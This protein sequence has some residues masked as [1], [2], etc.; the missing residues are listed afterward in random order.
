V[1]ATASIRFKFTIPYRGGVHAWSSRFHFD[2]GAPA[3]AAHWDTL[4]SAIWTS[5][6]P[7]ILAD[8]LLTEV[9]GYAPGAGAAVYTHPVASEGGSYV[10]SGDV[11]TAY[12]AAVLGW[13]TDQR[14]V[15]NHPIYLRNFIHGVILASADPGA[16]IADAQQTA[17]RT[18]AHAF[19]DA[20]GGFSDG[21]VT[22][23]R[24]GPNGAV[25]LDGGCGSWPG[26]RVLSR[27]G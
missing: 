18:F 6:K 12:I 17:L 27:R 14:D 15:R 16:Q 3:D 22:H 2:G 23:K 25:G 10:V 21:A 7:G 4:R 9:L 11:Q 20:G 8:V 13:S 26:H 5:L 24:A 1:A 19:S